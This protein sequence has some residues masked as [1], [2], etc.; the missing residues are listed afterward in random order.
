M[1]VGDGTSTFL[2]SIFGF[3][4]PSVRHLR[5]RAATAE[6]VI[7]VRSPVGAFAVLVLSVSAVELQGLNEAGENVGQPATARP[8]EDLPPSEIPSAEL[9]YPRLAVRAHIAE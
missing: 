1:D 7:E 2:R 9:A 8:I 4:D 5:V 3:V 6:R